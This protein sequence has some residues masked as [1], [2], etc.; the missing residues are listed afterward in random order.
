MYTCFVFTL[1]FRHTLGSQFD[2][3]SVLRD[4]P[5]L[6]VMQIFWAIFR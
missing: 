4:E 6:M 1:L 2:G 5:E 3:V